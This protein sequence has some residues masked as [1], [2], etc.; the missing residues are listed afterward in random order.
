M[1]AQERFRGVVSSLGI[2]EDP[3]HTKRELP[4][5]LRWLC[6]SFGE[7]AAAVEVEVTAGPAAQVLVG[8]G[9][10]VEFQEK[11]KL[12][13]CGIV[14]GRFCDAHKCVRFHRDGA[15]VPIGGLL[16]GFEG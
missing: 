1:V 3:E 2:A 4:E 8:L 7:A 6:A 16:A 5:T 14:R 11:G 13:R 15:T 9:G 10:T 12:L